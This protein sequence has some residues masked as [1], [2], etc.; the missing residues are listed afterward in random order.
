MWQALKDHVI[1]E[2]VGKEGVGELKKDNSSSYYVVNQASEANLTDSVMCYFSTFEF[3]LGPVFVKKKLGKS[4]LQKMT[5]STG[6]PVLKKVNHVGVNDTMCSF[7]VSTEFLNG[8]LSTYEKT[9]L[10]AIRFICNKLKK[11]QGVGP[12]GKL[13]YSADEQKVVLNASLTEGLIN[14]HE[15]SP[16]SELYK[17]FKKRL[18]T[19]QVIK[20]DKTIEQHISF[21]K[22]KIALSWLTTTDKLKIQSNGAS[23]ATYIEKASFSGSNGAIPSGARESTL[24]AEWLVKETT[25][26]G[27][28]LCV[29]PATLTDNT[30]SEADDPQQR[31]ILDLIAITENVDP[32][33][34]YSV[35]NKR[36]FAGICP[37]ADGEIPQ[38]QSAIIPTMFNL[39]STVEVEN[40]LYEGENETDFLS[41][42]LSGSEPPLKKKRTDDSEDDSDT[43]SVDSD[44]EDDDVVRNVCFF[45]TTDKMWTAK[46]GAGILEDILD[47]RARQ[48]I[49][50]NFR[51]DGS[52]V[53]CPKF[54]KELL[55]R[56]GM[57]PW[58]EAQQSQREE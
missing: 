27:P 17:E 5:T 6:A 38:Q 58:R 3:N 1:S 42:Y 12:H 9:I 51:P 8:I 25:K 47:N 4:C 44:D 40:P 49:G 10:G 41:Q 36:I 26:P 7:G 43:E 22:Y 16:T 50:Q 24:S 56:A 39:P 52:P 11:E 57:M 29:T 53:R 14:P 19:H 20:D 2:G 28:T 35:I 48:I 31:V 37:T 13:M 45:N 32:D 54:V 23:V 33:D 18:T 15:W 30:A 55:Y 21:E 46:R 34:K